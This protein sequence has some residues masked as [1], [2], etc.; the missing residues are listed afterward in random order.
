MITSEFE[1]IF[2]PK[3]I[4]LNP[5][6]A[7]LDWDVKG[8]TDEASVSF[9]EE[10]GIFWKATPESFVF[11]GFPFPPATEN[12]ALFKRVLI[13]KMMNPLSYLWISK[14]KRELE[15]LAYI[16]IRR[17]FLKP[18]RYCKPVREV[19]RIASLFFKTDFWP[20][21]IAS[22]LQWDAAYRW[23]AQFYSSLFDKIALQKTPKREIQRVLDIIVQNETAEM[24]NK[25]SV[26]LKRFF[27]L[28]WTIPKTRSIIKVVIRE[29][30]LDELKMNEDDY[31][32]ALKQQT[33]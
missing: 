33:Q 24:M 26:F 27:S 23:R 21:I 17:Y 10:G 7:S 28:L 20:H 4:F 6:L 31:H 19:F 11:S 15:E 3:D 12:V 25:K 32:I 1:R 9:P 18:E 30:N 5:D 2:P 13:Q 16:S 8:N 29:V 22:I 14:T